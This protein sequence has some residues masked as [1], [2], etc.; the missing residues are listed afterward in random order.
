MYSVLIVDDEDLISKGIKSMILR[1]KH[2]EIGDISTANNATEAISMIQE[3]RPEIIITD[4]KMPKVNGLYLLKYIAGIK[5]HKVAIALSGH[6]DFDFV[7]GA[8]KYGVE[9]YILK[10]ADLDELRGVIESSIRKLKEQISKTAYEQ[11]HLNNYKQMLFENNVGNIFM[12][13]ELPDWKQQ[14]FISSLAEVFPHECF[15]LVAMWMENAASPSPIADHI[16]SLLSSAVEIAG[17]TCLQARS[18]YS[19][20]AGN[21]ILIFNATQE[22]SGTIDESIKRVMNQALRYNSHA[23]LAVSARGN[24]LNSLFSLFAQTTEV[25]SY[26]IMYERPSAVF[27]SEICGR[28]VNKD[29]I[30]QKTTQLLSLK[31]ISETY[32]SQVNSCIDNTFSG[33]MLSTQSVKTV[34][35]LY[36]R[37]I[38][39]I[40]GDLT[41]G[42]A[43]K[44]NAWLR[45]DT[46]DSL[47]DLRIYLKETVYKMT[48]LNRMAGSEYTV[49]DIAKNYVDE[50]LDS[51]INLAVIANK[52][53][54]SYSYLSR[55]F[56]EKT[57][58]AFTDYVLMTKMNS[59]KKL[60][61]DPTLQIQNIAS[62][63]GY[64]NPKN[65]TRAFKSYFGVSPTYYQK[66]LRGG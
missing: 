40:M 30:E 16:T 15:Y 47:N 10:P 45:F 39:V 59:A 13:R 9:D 56:K 53:S 1:L 17:G 4:I 37:F 60:L 61:R 33:Y 48:A 25:M 29:L 12:N 62:K 42:K 44:D 27:F 46:F 57:G 65:F 50:H 5:Y 31:S 7:K 34:K 52:V 38:N 64:E 58:L 41:A 20:A 24:T 26:R 63:I 11:S 51:E 21:E 32:V 22:A 2:P 43:L 49:I 23:Y 54:L 3:N 35:Q 19:S 8:F 18:T 66:E 55:L 28:E 6:D 14:E 36:E